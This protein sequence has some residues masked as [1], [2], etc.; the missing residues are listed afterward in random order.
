MCCIFSAYKECEEQQCT[1]RTLF[2]VLTPYLT[3]KFPQNNELTERHCSRD[4]RGSFS[5]LV[6]NPVK[7]KWMNMSCL[8]RPFYPKSEKFIFQPLFSDEKDLFS[9]GPGDGARLQEGVDNIR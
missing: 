2:T 6:P 1:R 3:I 4:H 9:P 7:S 5:L 8:N